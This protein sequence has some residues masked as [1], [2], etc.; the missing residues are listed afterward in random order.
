MMAWLTGSTE[1]RSIE[2][3]ELE[4]RRTA[5]DAEDLLN[6]L[7]VSHKND[8]LLLNHATRLVQDVEG[9][10]MKLENSETKRSWRMKLE[11]LQNEL[12]MATKCTLSASAAHDKDPSP[13]LQEVVGDIDDLL[14]GLNLETPEDDELQKGPTMPGRKIVK[15]LRSPS[16]IPRPPSLHRQW[17]LDSKAFD[18]QDEI[19]QDKSN[20][21]A[22]NANK[23]AD[24]DDNEITAEKLQARRYPTKPLRVELPVP[25]DIAVAA[26]A[27]SNDKNNDLIFQRRQQHSHGSADST[28]A[29]GGTLHRSDS[30]DSDESITSPENQENT[31]TVPQKGFH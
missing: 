11:D 24:D 18:A 26:A 29:H 3:T 28:V 17:T 30:M 1:R 13:Q 6:S 20:L 7:R 10:V 21:N 9:L 22:K 4:L 16:G 15:V 27:V 14:H 25:H 5:E 2:R 31:T 23:T 12:Q 19:G 8:Q